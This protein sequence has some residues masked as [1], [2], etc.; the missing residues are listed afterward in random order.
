[1]QCPMFGCLQA[2]YFSS[3]LLSTGEVTVLHHSYNTKVKNVDL[4]GGSKQKT[5]NIN[6]V[7]NDKMKLIS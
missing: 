3:P 4:V 1:M 7:G 6:V 2:I 5:Y